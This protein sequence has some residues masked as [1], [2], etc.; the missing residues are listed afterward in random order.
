M[1]TLI[2]K[3]EIDL[4]IN[5]PTHSG[6][7]L[8]EGFK[9]RRLAI[10]HLIPLIT[11]LQLAIVMLHCLAEIDSDRLEVRSWREIQGKS[12]NQNFNCR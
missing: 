10:D 12:T 9:I 3:Q 11:N 5:I 8:S 6:A 1:A 4:I 2:S 7:R